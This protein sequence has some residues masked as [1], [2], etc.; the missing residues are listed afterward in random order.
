MNYTMKSFLHKSILGT[1][2]ADRDGSERNHSALHF[3][4]RHRQLFPQGDT[5][6]SGNAQE[7]AEAPLPDAEVQIILR[8]NKSGDEHPSFLTYFLAFPPEIQFLVLSF[9]DFGD[10]ERLR[11]TCKFFRIRISK[12]LIRS[13]FPEWS[14]PLRNTCYLCLTYD[15]TG[16][17][18]IC[19]DVSDARYPL[20][21][22]C[23]GCFRKGKG[24]MVG[25]K[26]LMGN[27]VQRYLCRW[28]GDLVLSSPAQNRPEYHELCFGRYMYVMFAYY[29]FG[30]TQFVIMIVAPAICWHYYK[31][32]VAVMVPTIVSPCVFR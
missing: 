21:S 9:L 18:V 26:Y 25:R 3:I 17:E 19:S 2:G 29:I 14:T 10:I 22:L 11:R 5:T 13:L 4:L 12:P 30:L 31:P 28:C 15:P 24:F 8:K 1:A 6:T 27:G 32:L 7:Q 23:I 16:S 20:S